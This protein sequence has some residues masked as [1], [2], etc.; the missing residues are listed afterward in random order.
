MLKIRYLIIV[1]VIFNISSI[2]SGPCDV[3]V[4]VT[5]G[6]FYQNG[7]VYYDDVL[8]LPKH[9]FKEENQTKAC[10][11]EYK[12]CVLKCCDHGQHFHENE[13]NFGDTN[14]NLIIHNGEEELDDKY[15]LLVATDDWCYNEGELLIL[16]DHI[17]YEDIWKIQR[18][19]ELFFPNM[20]PE[21]NRISP[22]TYCVEYFS[23]KNNTLV[24]K[25]VNTNMTTNKMEKIVNNTMSTGWYLFSIYSFFNTLFLI[26]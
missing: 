3:T 10:V 4:D 18:N 11:C 17:K 23:E 26:N 22:F 16:L 9:V 21:L 20:E 1:L 24:G 25:C 6:F 5:D 12:T 7:S 8:Y 14:L 13:C 2:F 19:G 15:H